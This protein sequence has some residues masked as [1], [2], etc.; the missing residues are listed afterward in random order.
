M[1][2]PL[3]ELVKGMVE[4]TLKIPI[5]RTFKLDEAVEAHTLMEANKAGGKVVF[6]M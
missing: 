2:T 4:G 5:G 6:L 3:D 1:Q